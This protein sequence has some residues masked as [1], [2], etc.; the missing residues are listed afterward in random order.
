M[1]MTE[2]LIC[3]VTGGVAPYTYSWSDLGNGSSRSN[4]SAGVY[5]VIITDSNQCV[6]EIEIEI[7]NAI[8]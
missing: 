4:L 2:Q 1:P 5:K 6:K 8:I 3:S 7:E